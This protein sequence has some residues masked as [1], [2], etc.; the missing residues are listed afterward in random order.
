VIFASTAGKSQ[1]YVAFAMLFGRSSHT[2]K[3]SRTHVYSRATVSF[4]PTLYSLCSF[5][6]V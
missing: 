1:D 2:C 4:Y 6:C 3:N 5:E